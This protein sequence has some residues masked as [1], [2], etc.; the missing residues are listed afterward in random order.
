VAKKELLLTSREVAHI[1][2]LSPD[3]VIDLARRRKLRAIKQGRFWRFGQAD[4]MAYKR[5]RDEGK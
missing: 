2:D 5:R 3:D 4:I 1:L